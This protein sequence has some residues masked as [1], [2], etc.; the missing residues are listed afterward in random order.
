MPLVGGLGFSRRLHRS[1][2]QTAIL[3]PALLVV[4][5]VFKYASCIK[6]GRGGCVPR[7][8]QSASGQAG[9]EKWTDLEESR[10]MSIPGS[11]TVNLVVASVVGDDI[12]WTSRISIPNMAIVRYFTDDPKAQYHPVKPKGR[13]A[14]MYLTYLHDFYDK[15]PDISILI[16]AHEN[17]WHVES[18]L[19]NNLSFALSH[20][21]L[22]E[23]MRRRYVNLRVTWFNSCPDW[24]NTSHTELDFNEQKKEEPYMK[25]MFLDN[26]MPQ[27]SYLGKTLEVPEIIAQP[28]CNQ[29]AVTKEVIRTIPHSE[30]ARY[31]DWLA[32]TELTDYISGRFWEHSFQY[33]FTGKAVDCPVEYKAFCKTYHVCFENAQRV[34]EFEQLGWEKDWC[35]LEL[36]FWKELWKPEKGRKARKRIDE[37][38][39]ELDERLNEALQRGQDEQWIQGL[40]DLYTN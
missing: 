21:D 22:A 10:T 30:F 26:F 33:L 7:L 11:P 12:S 32:S 31:I 25:Q 28:C 8:W 2:L 29:F 23:V 18:M 20:L 27:E 39:R 34:T 4:F 36:G 38:D 15:L 17:P 14:L 24:I 6:N 9:L 16:H 1:L 37:I 3:I 13:E 19:K 40:G 5:L 35:L